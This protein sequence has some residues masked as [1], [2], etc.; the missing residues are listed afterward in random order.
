MLFHPRRTPPTAR[1]Y[2]ARDAAAP[3]AIAS[4]DA[5][6]WLAGPIWDGVWVLNGI[7]IGGVQALNLDPETIESMAVLDPTEATATATG[8]RPG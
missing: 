2:Q 8:S 4:A 7:P 5:S 3:A 6:R 1:G